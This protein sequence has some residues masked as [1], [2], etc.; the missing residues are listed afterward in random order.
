[1][2]L[3][4]H[5][6]DPIPEQTARIPQSLYARYGVP[7]APAPFN[8]LRRSSAAGDER[9]HLAALPRAVACG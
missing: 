1:M 2:S 7:L 3:R 4:P 9:E 6:V 5:T 8:A